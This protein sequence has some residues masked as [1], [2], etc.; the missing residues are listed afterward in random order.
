MATLSVISDA[1]L[2]PD[3]TSITTAFDREF[4]AMRRAAVP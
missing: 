1:H 4:D 3:P 2:I